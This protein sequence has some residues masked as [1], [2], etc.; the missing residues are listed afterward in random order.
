M[1]DIVS[2]LRIS[3][4]EL[5]KK[6]TDQAGDLFFIDETIVWTD[7]K[8]E[9]R[10]RKKLYGIYL[11][12][13]EVFPIVFDEVAHMG[14][15]LFEV[16]ISQFKA[17]ADTSSRRLSSFD[18]S[19]FEI[20]SDDYVKVTARKTSME[21]VLS[22]NDLRIILPLSFDE[23]GRFVKPDLIWVRKGNC[24]DYV[25]VRDGRIMNV[26]PLTL[27]YDNV[28]GMAGLNDAG[29]AV[30]LNNEGRAD[31]KL[32]RDIVMKAGGHL[33][34]Q[35]YKKKIEHIIDVYGNILNI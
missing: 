3:P 6:R 4:E 2:E 23:V 11:N 33:V 30:I 14:G 22:A 18:Y 34:L 35:N 31:G 12:D 9:I 1:N 32:L 19:L 20:L 24:Y 15:N 17:I 10:K 8:F 25:N 29:H 5:I 21:G 16:K 27:V 7:G 26:C 28:E 13:T